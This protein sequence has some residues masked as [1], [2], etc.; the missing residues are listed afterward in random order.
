MKGK[1]FVFTAVLTLF[2][3]FA[4]PAWA[5]HLSDPLEEEYFAHVLP[6]YKIDGPWI[7]VAIFADTSFTDPAAAPDGEADVHL[8]FFDQACNLVRDH[9][10]KLTAN[11]VEFLI[12]DD[13]PG[14]PNEGVVFADTGV[15]SDGGFERFLTYLILFNTADN[16]LVRLDSIPFDEANG[17]WLRY[18]TFNTIA[19]TFGDGGPSTSNVRTTLMFF[20]ALGGGFAAG[21]PTVIGA[22]DTLREFLLTYGT[23]FSG[24]W[25]TTGSP[26]TPGTMELDA[27]DDDE[28]FLGSFRL[29]PRCFERVRLGTLIPALIDVPLGHVV[30]FALPDTTRAACLGGTCDFSGFQETVGEAGAVDLMLDGYFH[31]SF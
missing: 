30:A 13:L 2:L 11:D 26:V 17:F 31:H 28:N 18:D 16:T 9:L 12:L 5:I 21:V 23:P 25:L 4:A 24:D 6:F 7:S 15:F 3:G 29:N 14:I 10:V 1:G 20:N 22:I 19:A 8:F 27:F